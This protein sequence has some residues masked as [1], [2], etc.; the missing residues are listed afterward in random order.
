MGGGHSRL[1]TPRHLEGTNWI[2]T[3]MSQ[4]AGNQ[5]CKCKGKLILESEVRCCTMCDTVVC[6]DCYSES[7]EC[8][9]CAK[10]ISAASPK[11][12]SSTT[13]EVKLQSPPNEPHLTIFGGT[14]T[15]SEYQ[16]A[17]IHNRYAWIF[18]MSLGIPILLILVILASLTSRRSLLVAP[19]VLGPLYPVALRLFPGAKNYGTTIF[20]KYRIRRSA[21]I[22]KYGKDREAVC[23]IPPGKS[24][25]EKWG[26]V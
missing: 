19:V 17:V 11:K 21:I 12:V 16:R 4:I 24:E 14:I 6:N 2:D 3:T 18:M 5:C 9:S 15:E 10:P 25:N 7:E 20:R 13:K 8:P 22:A 26:A 23:S 1:T